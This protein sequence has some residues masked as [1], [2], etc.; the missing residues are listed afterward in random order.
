MSDEALL[1]LHEQLRNAQDKYTYFLLAAVGGAVALALNRTQNGNLSYSLL[2]LAAAL[3]FWGLSFYFGCMHLAYVR[4]NM[5]ANYALLLVKRGEHPEI[6][7]LP[8]AAAVASQG[9]R[10][11][12]DQNSKW[13]ET[14]ARWQFR[15]LLI[16]ALFYIAWHIV[17]MTQRTWTAS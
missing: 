5:Y 4:S 12:I 6:G 8:D 10:E 1:Q 3:L 15:L 9:I 13:V 16:G 7:R 14:Y 17:E 11:A 2:P